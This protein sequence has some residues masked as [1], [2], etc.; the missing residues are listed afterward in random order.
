MKIPFLSSLFA[1]PNE[2]A[3]APDARPFRRWQ[4]AL[5]I[6]STGTVFAFAWFA[7]SARKDTEPVQKPSEVKHF[8]LTANTERDSFYTRFDAR[9][10]SLNSQLEALNTTVKKQQAERD[11]LTSQINRLSDALNT[12]T[13]KAESD[14]SAREKWEKTMETRFTLTGE[15]SA[16]S[17]G[18]AQ[19]SEARTEL[20]NRLGVEKEGYQ[21]EDYRYSERG[22][23]VS[24]AATLSSGSANASSAALLTNESEVRSA[25][26]LT[27]LRLTDAP[28]PARERR[29][30][31]QSANSPVSYSANG[32]RQPRTPAFGPTPYLL[33]DTPLALNRAMGVQGYIA[34]GSFAPATLLTGAYVMTGASASNMP[35]PVLLRLVNTAILPNEF[36]AEVKGCFV[37]GAATGDLSS[38]RILVRLDRLACTREDGS[39]LDVSVKGYVVGEDGKVGVRGKLITRSGQAIAA[40]ISMGLLS[41][42][43]NAITLTS[44]ST[45]TSSLGFQTTEVRDAWRHGLGKGL[46]GAMDR[47]VDYY[48]K[49][50]DQIFPVLECASGRQVEAVFAQGVLLSDPEATAVNTHAAPH[51]KSTPER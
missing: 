26:H 28:A 1:N 18:E 29:A 16:S 8:S 31:S 25:R 49:I 43:G 32:Q 38:E 51:A 44:E 50:A 21:G 17:L 22:G 14:A 36:Q 13:Q 23:Y 4:I 11:A 30:R 7:M 24:P 40:A 19:K 2:K 27:E 6:G 48:L 12:L 37:T 39:Q 34:A 41:G 33:P 5:L 42:V 3:P 9:V 15:E 45:T 35:I 46:S 10:S 20:R 47:I